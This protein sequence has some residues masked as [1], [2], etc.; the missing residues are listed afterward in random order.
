MLRNAPA[1]RAAI[2]PG[3][4]VVD[5]E[6]K[7]V[8]DSSSLLNLISDLPPNMDAK[9]KVIRDQKPMNLKVKIGTRPKVEPGDR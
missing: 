4:I 3:D 7:A 9:I 8:V 6:G 5:I 1:D 2:K